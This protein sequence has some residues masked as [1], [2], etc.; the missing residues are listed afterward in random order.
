MLYRTCARE[1]RYHR[2]DEEQDQAD[3]GRDSYRP[4]RPSEPDNQPD[5]SGQL[6]RPQC[7]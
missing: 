4:V 7:R 6:H 1:V 3:R 2:A 5:G